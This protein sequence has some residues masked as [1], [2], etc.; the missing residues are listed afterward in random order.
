MSQTGH[1]PEHN[2]RKL[3]TYQ[4]A[5]LI[6]VL[7]TFPTSASRSVTRRTRTMR[8]PTR[9]I[10]WRSSKRSAGT[11]QDPRPRHPK[12]VPLSFSWFAMRNCRRARKRCAM[13]CGFMRL[14]LRLSS[15]PAVRPT[16]LPCGSAQNAILEGS[17]DDAF[18]VVG[19]SSSVG[20]SL[21]HKPP[22]AK[23]NNNRKRRDSAFRRTPPQILTVSS[24]SLA[25]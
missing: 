17:H 18:L 7:R 15:T 4:K 16:H 10:L 6:Q 13:P 21:R 22:E 5:V 23:P 19:L 25:Q 3:T 8:S 11:S 9:R 20:F 14:Q 12:T 1:S 24:S 2:A